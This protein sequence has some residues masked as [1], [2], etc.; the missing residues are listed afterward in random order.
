MMLNILKCG[1][2]SRYFGCM[3]IAHM[4]LT[5]EAVFPEHL[6]ASATL[7]LGDF[8]SGVDCNLLHKWMTVQVHGFMW[9]DIFPNMRLVYSP[10]CH[11]SPRPIDM[12]CLEAGLL[13]LQII[14]GRDEER[15]VLIK[16][17]LLDYL[18]C[19]PWYIQEGCGAHRRV[20]TLLEMVSSHVPLQPPSLSNIVRAKLA[21]T[22]CGLKK[23]VY[24]D[25]YAVTSL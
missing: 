6:A 17:G 2:I 20:R 11:I 4:V 21:A 13:A 16:Q 23:A 12:L 10:S 22:H 15:Q 18:T 7:F 25:W 24:S 14:L 5:R 8:L 1:S 3:M 19:L 9:Q